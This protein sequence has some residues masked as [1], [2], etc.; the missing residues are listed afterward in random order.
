M[1]YNYAELQRREVPDQLP[2]QIKLK[3]AVVAVANLSGIA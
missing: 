1:Y 3:R 2:D